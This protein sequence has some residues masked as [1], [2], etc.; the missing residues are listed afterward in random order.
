MGTWVAGCSRPRTSGMGWT[1]P[2]RLR[3]IAFWRS[4]KI[5][6]ALSSCTFRIFERRKALGLGNRAYLPSVH[7]LTGHGL[8]MST[9]RGN[10]T[11]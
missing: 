6:W 5:I 4:C 7:I 8:S 1:D 2:F 11:G 3:R 9:W 10:K